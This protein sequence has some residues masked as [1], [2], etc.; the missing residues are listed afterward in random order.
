[1]LLAV[2]FAV[3]EFLA[4]VAVASG[5]CSESICSVIRIALFTWNL[6][7]LCHNIDGSLSTSTE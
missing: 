6:L 7:H 2:Y 3:E 5:Q 1:M 4:F